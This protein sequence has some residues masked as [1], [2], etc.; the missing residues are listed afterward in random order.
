MAKTLKNSTK[1]IIKITGLIAIKEAFLLTTNTLGLIYHPFQTL[2]KIKEKKDKSQTI[3]ITLTLITTLILTPLILTLI[4]YFLKITYLNQLAF[5]DLFLTI[6][7]L[8]T[9]IYLTYWLIKVIK[10]K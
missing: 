3:L 9:L 6:I 10:N 8:T 1:R 5:L 7:G 2:N 4:C